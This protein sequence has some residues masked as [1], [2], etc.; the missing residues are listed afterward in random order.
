MVI[1]LEQNEPHEVRL[2]CHARNHC[3]CHVVR[4]KQ[5]IVNLTENLLLYIV[6]VCILLCRIT[7]SNIDPSTQLSI[8]KSIKYTLI[9]LF[10]Y[11]VRHVSAFRHHQVQ[12]Q[13]KIK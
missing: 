6:L 5:N 9:N 11:L 7:F 2:T 3:V 12:I 1:F 4:I 10:Y 13:I 8:H